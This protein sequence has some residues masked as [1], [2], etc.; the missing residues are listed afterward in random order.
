MWPL[1][2]L[3]TLQ[4]YRYFC[5]TVTEFSLL[6]SLQVLCAGSRGDEEAVAV[7]SDLHDHH[8]T[9]RIR[10]EQS[11]G[12]GNL[13]VPQVPEVASHDCHVTSHTIT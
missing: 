4:I 7:L 5:G 8:D 10:N 9:H 11:P 13:C 12:P 2:L 3:F 1:G 6:F